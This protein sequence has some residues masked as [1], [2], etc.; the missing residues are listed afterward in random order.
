MSVLI[1]E[2]RNLGHGSE[3]LPGWEIL[4]KVSLT[5]SLSPDRPHLLTTPDAPDCIIRLYPKRGNDPT[6]HTNETTDTPENRDRLTARN[7]IQADH[8]TA[9]LECAEGRLTLPSFRSFV[10]RLPEHLTTG[11]NG[12]ELAIVAVTKR[13]KAGRQATPRQN[14]GVTYGL[15]SYLRWARETNQT[16]VFGD[17]DFYGDVHTAGNYLLDTEAI[18]GNFD[19]ISLNSHLSYLHNRYRRSA[20]A[21][22]FWQNRSLIRKTGE[23]LAGL[24][25][26]ADQ[27]MNE[28]IQ[29]RQS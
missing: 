23:L 6:R 4:E 17:G 18:M 13:I 5:S 14:L 3:N 16:Q 8:L 1:G 7:G 21:S 2:I 29:N 27:M 22:R 19:A 26:E 9:L 12:G 25:I 20:S 11:Q 28:L 15:A 10:A 24:Q